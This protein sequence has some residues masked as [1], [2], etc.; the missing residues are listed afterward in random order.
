MGGKRQLCKKNNWIYTLYSGTELLHYITLHLWLTYAAHGLYRKLGAL[1]A[2][3]LGCLCSVYCT[4]AA[5]CTFT[6]T[7]KV[8]Q[9]W[10]KCVV[11]AVLPIGK[12]HNIRIS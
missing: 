10:G 7:V 9:C 12:T 5:T 4:C 11:N 6:V 2:L 3:C 1:T 8:V